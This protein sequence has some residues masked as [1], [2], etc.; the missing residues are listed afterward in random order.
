MIGVLVVVHVITALLLIFIVLMQSGKGDGISDIFGGGTTQTIFGTSAGTFLTKVTTV[1]AVIFIL[2]SLAFSVVLSR[3]TRSLVEQERTS[4]S[5]PAQSKPLPVPANPALPP[6]T[7][8]D[9]PQ[10]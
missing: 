1:L 6:P 2:T 3:R 7:A 9:V 5:I 10:P 8:G 4:T